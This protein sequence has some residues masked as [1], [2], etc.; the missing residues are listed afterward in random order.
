MSSVSNDLIG[1]TSPMNDYGFYDYVLVYNVDTA[2]YNALPNGS[3]KYRF[4]NILY[5]LEE[6]Q[7]KIVEYDIDYVK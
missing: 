5:R 3:G 1:I 2:E 7:M 4:I 6:N